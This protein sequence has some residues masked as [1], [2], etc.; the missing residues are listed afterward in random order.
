MKLHEVTST[1]VGLI[2]AVT[3]LSDV[4]IFQNTNFDKRQLENALKDRGLC[5]VVLQ[6]SGE[7]SNPNA[8]DLAL[9]NMLIVSVLENPVTNTGGP[10]A[11]E[12]VGYVLKAIHQHDWSA[13]GLRNVLV[14]DNPAYTRGDLENGLVTYFCNFQVKTIE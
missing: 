8:P 3:E 4:L 7:P 2:E 13:P 1:A 11:L 14:V 9:T 6:E 10:S 5:L 12:V